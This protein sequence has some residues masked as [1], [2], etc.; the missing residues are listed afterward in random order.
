MNEALNSIPADSAT[1]GGQ[2]F[3]SYSHRNKEAAVLIRNQ[4]EKNRLKVFH[5]E[6][7]IRSGDQ[8]MTEIESALSQCSAFIVLIGEDGIR[9]WVGAEVQ[10]AL[11]RNLSP[12][13]DSQRLHIF[14]IILP[15]GKLQSL[16]PFLSLFQI[17]EWQPEKSLPQTLIDSIANH[18]ELLSDEELIQGSPYLGLNVFQREDA[19]LFFGRQKE[20]LDALNLIGDPRHSNPENQIQGSGFNWW[21]QIEGNSG[22]GKSSFVNAGLLPLIEKD[23]LWGQTGYEFWDVIGKMVPGQKPLEMLAELLARK[24]KENSMSDWVDQLKT[25]ENIFQYSLREQKDS[26]KAFLLILD[27]FEELLTLSEESQ[28]SQFESQISN[29]LSDTECPFFLISSIRS[30]FLGDLDKLPKLS[31]LYNR[32]CGRY[33]LGA[34]TDEG[35]REIIEKPARLAGLDVT[36]VTTAIVNDARNEIG[37]LPLVENALHYLW[38]HSEGNALDG[39]LYN[40]KG[41]IA[42]LLENQADAMLDNMGN[43]QRKAALELLL[44]L[45]RI[46]DAGRNTR[47]RV[48]LSEAR[49]IAGPGNQEAGQNLI[50]KLAGLGGRSQSR[51]NTGLRLITIAK[52]GIDGKDYVDL[53]HETLIRSRCKDPES[54]RFIGYWDTLFVYIDKHRDRDI[55]RQQLNFQAKSWKNSQWIGRWWYLAG[56]RDM[57]R[58]K[59]LQPVKGSIESTY[60]AWSRRKIWASIILIFVLIAYIG[61]SYLWTLKHELPLS[62]IIELQRFRTGY[63]PLPQ[64]ASLNTSDFMLG[65]LD[66]EFI[67][68]IPASRY[69]NFGYPPKK[70]R[71]LPSFSISKYEITYEQFDHFVWDIQRIGN[72]K[73]IYPA[74][75]K[76]GRGQQPAVYMTWYDANQYAQWLGKKTGKSCRLPFE[77]EWEY[78]AKAGKQTGYPWGNSVGT[79][80]ASCDGCGSEWDGKQTAPV[81]QFEANDFGL[82]DMNGNVWEWTSTPWVMKLENSRSSEMPKVIR[83]GSLFEGPAISRSTARFNADPSKRYYHVGFRVVCS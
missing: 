70:L 50:D 65:E 25:N 77:Q 67:K 59:F 75:A 4:L 71:A 44:R 49:E 16:P 66:I 73:V 14:P 45:T 11:N 43:K 21:L 20:T 38:Q 22:S 36:E 5:D 48:P 68:S 55:L 51:N 61:E 23:A 31:N 7:S 1:G 18:V 74:T 62:S 72:S 53:I 83:G 46:N 13:D 52:E 12:H 56:F 58:Y 39:D 69:N 60:L 3:L 42:G 41:G 57:H 76:G 19:H 80:H 32:M 2:V 54:G 30:D 9:R 81:G 35:L 10:V 28:R 29:A 15:S 47:Q 8:W 63:E 6:K 34:I 79:N 64:L 40:E 17:H 24:F 33:R 82:Y 26:G 78:A 27:Q 37:A